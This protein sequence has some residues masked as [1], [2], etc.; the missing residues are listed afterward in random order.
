MTKYWVAGTI[1]NE[2]MSVAPPRNKKSWLQVWAF[3]LHISLNTDD[4][5]EIIIIIAV[6][7]FDYISYANNIGPTICSSRS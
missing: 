3:V 7:W 1:W 2:W 6:I 5:G 4:C